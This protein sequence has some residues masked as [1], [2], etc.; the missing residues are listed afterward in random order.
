MKLRYS[1]VR[2]HFEDPKQ[3]DREGEP[4]NSY[5]NEQGN[6]PDAEGVTGRSAN[7]SCTNSWDGPVV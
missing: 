2:L 5:E 7:E 4:E 3:K 1:R 6:P